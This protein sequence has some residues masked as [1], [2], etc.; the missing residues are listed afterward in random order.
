M[1]GLHRVLLALSAL[2]VFGVA[3][4]SI[5][6]DASLC[7]AVTGNLVQ[8]CGFESGAFGPWT[9]FGNTNISGVAIGGPSTHSGEHGAYFGPINTLGFLTQTIATTPGGRYSLSFYLANGGGP[10]NQ[11]QVSFNGVQLSSQ[12]NSAAFP[13]TLFT[14]DNLVVDSASVQLQFAFSQNPAHL[15]LDDVVVIRDLNLAPVPE[16]MSMVLLSSGLV[17]LGLKLRKNRKTRIES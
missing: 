12:L 8:N 4:P 14:F 15:F 16:P 6:A 13:Y 11:F 9:N 5:K 17:G 10:P 7:E 2:I 1:R 3:T